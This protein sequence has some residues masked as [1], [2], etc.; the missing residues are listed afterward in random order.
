MKKKNIIIISVLALL[1]ISLLLLIKFII[2]P[3]ESYKYDAKKSVD[4]IYTLGEEKVVR[5]YTP[6]KEAYTS[7]EVSG[8]TTSWSLNDRY[9]VGIEKEI[10]PG[11]YTIETKGWARF[12]IFVGSVEVTI[13]SQIIGYKLTPLEGT[14]C[15]S[16]EQ[17]CT[18]GYYKSIKQ[19]E[20]EEGDKIY[21]N[22]S[23]Y[24]GQSVSIRFHAEPYEVEH[25]KQAEK[26]E[27]RK[28]PIKIKESIMKNK[29]KTICFINEIETECSALKYY[30]DLK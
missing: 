21:V 10:K 3:A 16:A 30:K 7:E 19:V 1:I 27:I 18:Y 20:L 17:I 13:N 24:S 14:S 28:K 5:E 23:P 9:E 11:I 26:S 15:Y 4:K 25:M 8:V 6:K 29:N 2:K 12:D 22:Y